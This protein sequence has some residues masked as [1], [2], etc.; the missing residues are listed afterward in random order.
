MHDTAQQISETRRFCPPT[1]PVAPDKTSVAGTI[2]AALRNPLEMW[3]HSFF[4]DDSF[5]VK[6]GRRTFM[7][8]M[9]PTLAKQILLD[10]TICFGK[11]Y[12]QDRLLKPA[13]GEGLLTTDGDIWRQQR[14]AAAPAFR[15]GALQALVPSMA[16]AGEKTAAR[17]RDATKE[18]AVPRIDIHLDMMQATFD[19]IAETLLSATQMD[20]SY[21]QAQLLA[22]NEAFLETVGKINLLDILD[23]PRWIPRALANPQIIRGKRAVTRIRAFAAKQIK[24]RQNAD[25]P[26]DDLLSLL[27]DAR[28]PKTG[29]SLSD[30]QLL[31]NL[32]T[33]IGAG[34][35]TT[36]LALTWAISVISQMP[37]LQAQL[38]Q[39]ARDVLQDGPVTADNLPHLNLH[40]RVIMET[41]RLYPAAAVIPR[42]VIKPVNLDG[43]D[44]KPGDHIA[45]AVYP[46]HRHEKVWDDPNA[47]DPDRFLP[48]RI[49]ERHRF[50]WIPFGAGPR[51]CIGMKLSLME[52]VAILAN[53]T[54]DFEFHPDPEHKILPHMTVTLRPKGGMPVFVKRRL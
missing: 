40:E 9:S 24:L 20:A 53:M 41:L 18:G 34:H 49:K 51:I 38:A 54:R 48:E 30:Q 25:A 36:A 22:D 4:Q 15:H 8:L 11:S 39:E 44:L 28:D 37:E 35:E 17:L 26:E 2:T 31:D 27:I 32:V 46:L 10:D 5:T 21:T 1:V 47:F 3:T 7:H 6:W 42:S 43:T 23:A 12:M 52:A 13:F 14:R 45:I 50:A 29:D 33:F 16:N 19:V